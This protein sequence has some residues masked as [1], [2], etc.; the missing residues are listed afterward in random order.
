MSPLERYERQMEMLELLMECDL[1]HIFSE[2]CR[3]KF[4]AQFFLCQFQGIKFLQAYCLALDGC[5]IEWSNQ[6]NPQNYMP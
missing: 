4:Q 1:D 6:Q 3:P 5:I 2:A